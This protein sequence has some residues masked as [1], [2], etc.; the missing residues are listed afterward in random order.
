V[1]LPEI[2]PFKIKLLYDMKNL[3]PLK[4]CIK[5]GNDVLQYLTEEQQRNLIRYLASSNSFYEAKMMINNVRGDKNE[6][7]E[8]L[9]EEKTDTYTKYTLRIY[10]EKVLGLEQALTLDNFYDFLSHIEKQQEEMKKAGYILLV[11]Y[12][13]E[14]TEIA[15]LLNK[16]VVHK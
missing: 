10:N 4:V 2:T 15:A 9:E 16:E 12:F 5:N 3:E 8:R 11:N 6:L 14:D 7:L 1:H 13:Y